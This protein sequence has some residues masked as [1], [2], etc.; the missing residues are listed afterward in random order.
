ML[1]SLLVNSVGEYYGVSPK[2]FSGYINGLGI[3]NIK[4]DVY[5]LVRNEDGT[6]SISVYY[7][8]KPAMTELDELYIN[9]AALSNFDEST[10]QFSNTIGKIVELGIND[11]NTG[12][13]KF[14]VGEYGDK[15]TVLTYNSIVETVKHFKPAGY[16]VFIN[17]DFNEL[18]E[19]SNDKYTVSMNADEFLSE[20]QY[21]TDGYSFVLVTF[22]S[23]GSG[24]DGEEAETAAE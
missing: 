10:Q 5:S 7:A 1:F 19:I 6:G 4:N 15:N 9:E 16:D 22:G 17:T 8:S 11:G 2:L 18:K 3:N 21:P 24:E 12:S 20:Y 14:A 23:D 13:L